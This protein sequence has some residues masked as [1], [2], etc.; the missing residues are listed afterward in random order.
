MLTTISQAV[1]PVD[2][3]LLHIYLMR[4]GKG[5][6]KSPTLLC[7]YSTSQISVV[8]H[9]YSQSFHRNS[10]LLCQ[11]SALKHCLLEAQKP[12][13]IPLVGRH[14]AN[15]G[16]PSLSL[17]AI[18]PT[19]DPSTSCSTCFSSFLLL[20]QTFCMWHCTK[21][22]ALLSL[23]TAAIFSSPFSVYRCPSS[24]RR[25]CYQLGEQM[26]EKHAQTRCPPQSATH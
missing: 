12:H 15:M 21:N 9:H 2:L 8:I 4:K 22:S 1:M 14:W 17:P 13:G 16:L 26:R 24:H 10:Q 25:E 20:N 18:L 5:K 11:R 19:L 7:I 23:E 6:K 3:Y